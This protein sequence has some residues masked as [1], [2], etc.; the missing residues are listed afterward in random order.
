MLHF[1]YLDRS[2]EESD[3]ISESD[4]KD[5][6]CNLCHWVLQFMQIEDV[7]KEG[8]VVRL[9][10]SL[11]YILQFFFSHSRLSKYFVECLDFV[12]KTEYLL[13]P[14]QK[15]RVLEGAFVNLRG[16]IGENMEADLV[17]E[18]AV[19]NQKDLIRALGAN[20]TDSAI[21]RCS[22]AADTVAEICS[23]VDKAVT[24][25]KHSSRHR[26]PKSE[27]D[28]VV[29]RNSLRQLR[30]FRKSEGRSCLLSGRH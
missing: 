3:V 5:T 6:V 4:V 9:V 17:Q 23:N 11:K 21:A 28:E 13:S 24:V 30:P 18:N 16:G 8:D 25:K 14:M 10:P 22:K 26:V 1:D 2:H 19:R 7:V 15:L 27:K 20:K 29:I 12:L